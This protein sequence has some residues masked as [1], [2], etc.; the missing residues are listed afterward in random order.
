MTALIIIAVILV[1]FI[2]IYL[3]PG[4][5]MNVERSITILMP[6]NQVFEYIKITKNQDKFSIWNKQIRK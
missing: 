4:N 2:A 6:I 3:L 1:L 5:E